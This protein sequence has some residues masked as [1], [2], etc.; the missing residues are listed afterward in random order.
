MT[1][2]LVSVLLL[3]PYRL[4]AGPRLNAGE[5]IGLPPEA[6]QALVA[7]GMARVKRTTHP[8]AD[9]RQRPIVTK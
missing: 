3:K 1:Q 9:K 6:A 4:P 5:E 8:P 7:A 2:D